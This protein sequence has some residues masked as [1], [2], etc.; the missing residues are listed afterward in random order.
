MARESQSTSSSE[1][2]EEISSDSGPSDSSEEYAIERP[3]EDDDDDGEE[4]DDGDAGESTA[5]HLPSDGD[6][7]SKNVDAL[8]R[9]NLV[10]RRQ[11]L[12]PRVL[13][14][15]EGAAVCRKPFKP[16]CSSGYDNGKEDL[17]RR[18]WAR[19]RF[20]PWGTSRPALVA[21]AKPL[22]IIRTES[23]GADVEEE[24]VTLPPGI[25]PLVLWQPEESEDG[26]NNLVPIVVDPLLVRFLRPHQREGVQFMFECVSGLYSAANI[27][28]CILADDMG[29]G[30]TLQSI[31]LLYT[32][33]RQG[34][35]G[36]PMV[37]KAI[38]V[39]PTSL[40]SNWEAEIKKWVGQ[41]VQLIAL[42][43]SSRDDVVSGIDSFIN[44]CSFLRVLIVSYETFRM[45][46]SKFCQSEA[47]DLLICDEAHRLKNDQTITNRALAALSCK[48]RI[49]LSGTPMQNDLEEFFAM[50]NF[51]NPGILGDVAYFR[52]YYE[53]PIICGRE[54]TSSE[55]EKKLA[56]ERSSELSAKVNQFILRR[57]NAL[58][59]NHLPP[60]VKKVITEETKQTK[61]LAYITALKKL[62][63]HPKLIYD[64]IKSGSP[65]TTGFE[66][67]MRFFPPEMFSGRSGSWT[68]GDGAW[69]ELSGKMHVLARLLA[70][71][72]QR[73]DDRIVLV[74]NYTQT[75][76]LFAQLCRE[77]RYPY[78]R[79]DGTTSIGKRQKLVNRFNDS[80]KD[81]FV[82]LL[83][84]KAGGCGLNLI[85][86]NRLV[87][88]DPDWNPA[89][90]KQAAARVWRDGQKKRVYIY[91]FLSTG[92]IEE[93]VYQRQMSKEGLQ[94]VIQ[95]EQ[96]DSV[97]GQGNVFSTEDLRD[98]FTFYDSV[99]RFVSN[100]F[101]S[102]P[103]IEVTQDGR[104]EIHEK[105][106][107]NRCKN[108]G[109]GSEN[110]AEQE[111]SESENRSSGSDQEV[112]DIGGFAGIAGCLD[113][114][115]SS[116][117][118]VG[119]PL[120]EDL[121][122]WGHH[123]HSE[124]V[125]DAILQASAGDEVTFVFTNQVDG[126]LVPI[127]SKEREGSKRQNIG[128]VSHLTEREG[129]KMQNSM[130]QNLVSK[131]N[132][133]SKHHKPLN[134]VSS[135]RNSLMPPPPSSTSPTP[136]Q[137]K[138]YFTNGRGKNGDNKAEMELKPGLSALVTGGASG[139]G[140]ALCLTLAGKG[141]F[142]TIVDFSEE[143]GKEVASLVEKENSKFHQNLGF[144]SAISVKCDVTSL[145]D[146]TSAFEKHVST[147]G[148]L[149]ICINS[150]GIGT[151]ASFWKDQ[152]DGSKTWRHA[153]NVNLIAIKHMQALQKPGVI[154]NMGSSAGLYPMNKDPVYSASKGGVVMFTRSL[155]P[156]KRQGIRVNVICPEY[157]QTELGEKA[158]HKYV[159]LAGGYLKMETVVEGVLELIM[160]D[161]RAGSCLWVTNRRGK[162]YWPSPT[163]EAKYLFQS[164]SSSG[165]KNSF[166]APLSAQLP[167]SFEKVVVHK[168]SHNFRDATHIVRAQLKLPIESGHVLLKIIYAGVN[169]SDVNFSSG[170]YFLGNKKDISSLLPFDAGFEAVGI[171]AAVGDS[172]SNLE[173]GTPAAIM[174]YGGYAEF[175]AVPSKHILPIGR[176]D[177]EVVAMLTSG[178]TASIALEK[179]GQMESGKVVLVTAAAGG[180][181]QFAVQ[182]AKLAGNK[183]VATCGG[184][185]KARLLKDLGVDRVI[186]YRTEDI[187]TVLKEEFP[188]GVDI[189]Y[190][191]VGGDMFDLC[192]NALAIRGRLIVIGMISQ[193]QGEHGWMPKNYPGLVEKLLTKSQTVGGFFLPQYSYLWKEH[194]DKLYN[195]YSS[196]KLKVAIDPKRFLGLRS[197][198]DAVEHL[199]SGKSSGKVVVCI[200]PTFEQQM[201]KL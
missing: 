107:C 31:T 153:V 81:E 90:D 88:F 85:G 126:K 99:S 10:V 146:L 9:G 108:Y 64:T 182:L 74:S 79:L 184:K 173:V 115:K 70:H 6:L 52:R 134:S 191:S 100:I 138:I 49:L 97:M 22:G 42:C 27:N 75:L 51:T 18:L 84:S 23:D 34:F 124:S 150:A 189:V 61:I 19:K 76:D 164:S 15:T 48:R 96:V 30:K 135:N 7:K 188:K 46:S 163:E 105:M 28:G 172:V 144:P 190:E 71:L 169:A 63:N 132:F 78:L 16:P 161:S 141:V 133:L 57:T 119:S 129:N 186:D 68:G 53:T 37:K 137:A 175:M 176:P 151:P 140:K 125:P 178:L 95:Q 13:S 142:V 145:R 149:D 158:G 113:K 43:E 54:P 66:D 128:K 94:K 179:V 65:G 55:E 121:V 143:K 36:K 91:R 117:K 198:A 26:P 127:E 56:A 185:D 111:E 120:E 40:V 41:R 17:A 160:D 201:A 116:E 200:D 122:S 171:I 73:T 39:T 12:L 35:D 181:G 194:L 177:P 80:T 69:V 101:S 67:C 82:F 8:L 38:I 154:V 147:F 157:V 14:V 2:D 86:G 155:A 20:V 195:L 11:S 136:L 32:L 60:K 5:H 87:L 103:E 130:K 187:K 110:I 29:L 168:L 123:F 47:C 148:G 114:L 118:Q 196:G 167:Q 89:N 77:R 170:R 58:L 174:V 59:S 156:Y 45:H 1:E 165:E 24:T 72:R 44:P 62:C 3:D 106:N 180:T 33:L 102:V 98:L 83:S 104:S 139:I 109:T 93:K 199:H 112:F 50:V 193:Y 159:N 166:R 183:V 197:V 162:E 131:S 4:E 21:I 192:L 25:E 92:T 152:T